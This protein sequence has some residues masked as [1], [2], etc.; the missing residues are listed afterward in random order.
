MGLLCIDKCMPLYPNSEVFVS[1]QD[2]L[3][4]RIPNLNYQTSAVCREI[5]VEEKEE[6]KGR[7]M[8]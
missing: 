5:S 8:G 1:D 2:N 4:Y 6:R 3:F 7:W